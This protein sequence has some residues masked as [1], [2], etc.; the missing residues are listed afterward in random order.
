MRAQCGHNSPSQGRVY[1]WERR[2]KVRGKGQTLMM[3][4]PSDRLPKGVEVMVEFD[5]YNQGKAT[6]WYS[7]NVICRER[8]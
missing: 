1:N 8:Q 3:H 2:Y 5:Q 7:C 6:G 4:V